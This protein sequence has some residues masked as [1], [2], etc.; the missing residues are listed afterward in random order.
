MNL[1]QSRSRMIRPVVAF[2]AAALGLVAAASAEP[3]RVPIAIIVSAE[4]DSMSKVSVRE[5]QSVY[6]RKSKRLLGV[7]VRPVDHPPDSAIYDAFMKQVLKKSR[8]ILVDHWLEQA[9]TGG[10]RPPRQIKNSRAVIDFVSRNV[11]AIAYVGLDAL[12]VAGSPGVK[13]VPLDT[14]DGA[15]TP[16]DPGYDLTYTRK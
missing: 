11:G 3:D 10:T 2:V 12:D 16:S 13:I 1:R 8:K 14:R 9:L 6:L 4:L 5:L 7:A 15:M